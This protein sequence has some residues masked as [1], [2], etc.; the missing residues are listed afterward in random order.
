MHG[1]NIS[2]TEI[3]NYDVRLFFNLFGGISI[4]ALLKRLQLNLRPIYWDLT[5][6]NGLAIGIIIWKYT[7]FCP[8]LSLLF[9]NI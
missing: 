5:L 6:G 8:I 7:R 2:T 9:L 3:I 4:E 1:E